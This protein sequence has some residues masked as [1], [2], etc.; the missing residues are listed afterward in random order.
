VVKDMAK[1]DVI[2]PSITSVAAA[3]NLDFQPA[4][5]VEGLITAASFNLGANM[6]WF[7]GTNESIEV[8]FGTGD[9]ATRNQ[10]FITNSIYARLANDS[11]GALILCYRGV[12]TK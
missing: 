6:V 10:M 11:A 5:G 9:H 12:Q 4:A 8:S 3:G 2:G 1:R 7:D